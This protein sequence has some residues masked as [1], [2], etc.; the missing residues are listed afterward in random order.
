MYTYVYSV[1]ITV[2]AQRFGI[3]IQDKAKAFLVQNLQTGSEATQAAI[4]GYFQDGKA[5]RA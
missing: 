4:Q 5:A 3:R 2:Q 1:E